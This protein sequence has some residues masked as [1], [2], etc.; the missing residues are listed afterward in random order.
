MTQYHGAVKE[1]PLSE[2]QKEARRRNFAAF[3]VQRYDGSWID[4][5]SLRDYFA[6]QWLSNKWAANTTI[7]E[8][9]KIAYEVADAMIKQREDTE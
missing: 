3:P 9:A 4:G 2:K 8:T 7:E 1:E 5:M 6:G